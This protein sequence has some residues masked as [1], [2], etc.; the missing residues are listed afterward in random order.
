MNFAGISQK[1][2]ETDKVSRDFEQKCQNILESASRNFR[3]NISELL[4]VLMDQE[5]WPRNTP[6]GGGINRAGGRSSERFYFELR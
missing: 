3:N 1:C 6:P 4:E 2:S 5:P